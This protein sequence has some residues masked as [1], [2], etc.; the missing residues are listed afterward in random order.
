MLNERSFF[1]DPVSEIRRKRVLESAA[2]H[3]A[4]M[5]AAKPFPAAA[6]KILTLTARHDFD[7]TA[8]MRDATIEGSMTSLFPGDGSK[9][10]KELHEHAR[11]AGALARH[12]APEWRLPADEMFASA[13]LHDIGK[14]V[15]LDAEPEYAEIFTHHGKRFEGTLDEERGVFGFD[16]AE[17][18][19]HVL[20]A[21]AAPQPIA[22]VVGL[23]HDPAAAFDHSAG[24]ASRVALLRL[25]DRLA[26]AYAKEEDKIDFGDIAASDYC[27]YLGVSARALEERLEALRSICQPDEAPAAPAC[28]EGVAAVIEQVCADC[29]ATHIWRYC[30]R[31]DAP[32]CAEHAPDRGRI[33]GGCEV[34]LEKALGSPYVPTVRTGVIFTVLGLAAF[35]V[36]AFQEDARTTYLATA[37]GLMFA[38]AFVAFRRLGFRQRFVRPRAR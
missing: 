9:A 23:H 2:A 17:L 24:M 32:L 7:V 1:G 36:A 30:P 22:R 12:L 38:A 28:E 35:T 19:E 31:C 26:H 13:F 25:V 15:L 14:W 33:C 6:A 34:E 8:G 37:V 5:R 10:W 3:S 4:R 11:I 16:H 27:T 29:E 21:W 18:A 20:T